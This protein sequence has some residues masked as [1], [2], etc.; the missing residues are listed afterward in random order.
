MLPIINKTRIELLKKHVSTFTT[1]SPLSGIYFNC[2][3]A[4]ST[5]GSRLF[6]CLKPLELNGIYATDLS[7][8]IDRTFPDYEKLV[9][10]STKYSH[11]VNLLLNDTALKELI[12][13]LKGF[14]VNPKT[15]I[16]KLDF[17]DNQDDDLS[18]I[19][20]TS[21]NPDNDFKSSLHIPV[22]R[23]KQYK[24][25]VKQIAFNKKYLID[26]LSTALNSKLD[27]E[28]R[29][30]CLKWNFC[31]SYDGALAPLLIDIYIHNDD[32]SFNDSNMHVGTSLIMPVQL[33]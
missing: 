22:K 30:S 19:E 14:A 26:V 5:N 2:K 25:E 31:I 6:T 1:D 20:F 28:Y 27:K 8:T 12:N 4:A 10:D 13:C 33:R 3:K 7:R 15:N 11:R 16:V 9:P 24:A 32:D 23:M 21:K 17:E 29:L 18:F